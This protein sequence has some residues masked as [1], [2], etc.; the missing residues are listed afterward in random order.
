MGRAPTA[1]GPAPPDRRDLGVKMFGT[2]VKGLTTHPHSASV[3]RAHDRHVQELRL[4]MPS[5]LRGSVILAALFLVILS[6]SAARHVLPGLRE[7]TRAL[8]TTTMAE[9][10]ASR[11]VRMAAGNAA[12][13]PI[14]ARP[15]RTIEIAVLR[16]RPSWAVPADELMPRSTHADH[17]AAIRVTLA[18][19]GRH[20]P[21]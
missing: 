21:G 19:H 15:T 17:S 3:R 7:A 14:G 6:A 2:S 20:G 10:V 11:P 4:R 16:T 9:K 5:P 13:A 12:G 18:G 8:S 1:G